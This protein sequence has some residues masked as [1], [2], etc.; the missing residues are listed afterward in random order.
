MSKATVI[1][2]SATLFSY[3]FG[4]TKFY[5]FY[6]VGDQN[7]Y[8]PTSVAGRTISPHVSRKTVSPLEINSSQ[9]KLV[10]ISYQQK[11]QNFGV[12]NNFFN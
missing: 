8:A 9:R 4:S 7:G 11:L 12:K 3:T 6:L 2:Q 1:S 5:S 10:G